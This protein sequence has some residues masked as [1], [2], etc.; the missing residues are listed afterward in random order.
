[1]KRILY[2]IL[3][4]STNHLVCKAERRKNTRKN[5]SHLK[6]GDKE[7]PKVCT[8]RIRLGYEHIWYDG[9]ASKELSPGTPLLGVGKV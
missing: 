8:I 2:P 4:K 5:M 9:A 7:S 1:M 6:N 3:L